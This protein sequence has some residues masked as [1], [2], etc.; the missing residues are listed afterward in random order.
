MDQ[1]SVMDKSRSYKYTLTT[2]TQLVTASSSQQIKAF[3][4]ALP[5]IIHRVWSWTETMLSL[6]IWTNLEPFLHC[7]EHR[8]CFSINTQIAHKKIIIFRWKASGRRWFFRCSKIGICNRKT[9]WNESW[10]N[11]KPHVDTCYKWRR[12]V[13]KENTKKANHFYL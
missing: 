4:S 8:R 9:F 6:C 3:A 1:T 2:T 12:T 5:I 11:K 7:C 10:T 13:S